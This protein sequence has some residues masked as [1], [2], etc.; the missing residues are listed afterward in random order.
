[1][2]DPQRARDELG[3]LVAGVLSDDD[4]VERYARVVWNTL[5]EPGDGAAGILTAAQGPVEALARVRRGELSDS[6]L[7]RGEA[8][9]ALERWEPRMRPGAVSAVLRTARAARLHLVTPADEA[10]PDAA[11]DLGPH[12]PL[13]LWV[14]GDPRALEAARSGVAIVGARAATAYGEHVAG[15]FAAELAA[16]GV[17]VVSGAAFGI[18]AAAHRASLAGGGCTVA[19]MAGGL[20][21]A[22]PQAHTELV[23]RIAATGAV[24]SEVAPGSA[25]TKWRFLQRNRLIAALSAATVVVEAGWRSG[26]VNTAHHASALGRPLGAVPGPVTSAASAGCHRLLRELEATCVTT[27]AEVRELIGWGELTGRGGGESAPR[28]TDATRVRDALSRRVA[29][30]AQEVARRSGLGVADVQSHLGLLHLDGLVTAESEGWRL[31]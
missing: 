10:W 18:D 21:R 20:E 4:V 22:Y 26:S 9:L 28:T 16:S 6:V 14:R 19:L 24:V 11:D 30:S 1:M 15:E 29:R 7:E 5:T 31:T 25:P 17:C 8:R 2:I 23:E 13:V 27:A 12:A 3:P